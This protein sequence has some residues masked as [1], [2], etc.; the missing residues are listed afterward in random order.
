MTDDDA[1]RHLSDE[2]RKIWEECDLMMR[3]PTYDLKPIPTI[4]LALLRELATAR[5]ALTAFAEPTNWEQRT[6]AT[7]TWEGEPGNPIEVA[8]ASLAPR[9]TEGKPA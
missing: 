1:K 7:Y 8:R 9:P 4:V 5:A 3:Y 6:C 2:Q